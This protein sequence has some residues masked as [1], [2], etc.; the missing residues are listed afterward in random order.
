MVLNIGA[1]KLNDE[2]ST[3]GTKE[4]IIKVTM[5]II[6]AEGFQ[7]VTVRKIATRAG[8]NIA[9]V[10]YHYGCKDAVINEALKTVTSKLVDAF[11][12]L[13]ENNLNPR[14]KLRMF[15]VD[16]TNV[17]FL[18]P[19]IIKTVIDQNI[20]N[21]SMRIAEEYQEYVIREGRELI[22]QVMQDIWPE[23]SMLVSNMR[24]LQILSCMAFPV[25]IGDRVTDISLIDWQDPEIRE[26]YT[27]LL[28][29]NI[30][31]R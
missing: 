21:Q 20:H 30:A 28:L 7:N 23:E 18:Y 8:V 26:K 9:A 17:L 31:N 1:F 24:A 25:L 14:E 12:H 13:K 22:A 6:A 3:L 16:Y 15:V 4:R 11:R 29:N 19:D 2:L 10:N 5:E 27:E